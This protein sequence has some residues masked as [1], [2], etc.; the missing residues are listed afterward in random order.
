M[1]FEGISTNFN[2]LEACLRAYVD[3]QKEPIFLSSG[4]ED[5]FLGTYYFN[6]GLYHN[7]VAGL[8]HGDP[9]RPGSSF[10]FSAYRFHEDDPIP[11]RDGLRLG[12]RNGEEL[13]GH[14]FGDPKPTT[15]TSY[16]WTYE[17]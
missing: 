9:D 7:P 3:G 15:L 14:R 11:F 1:T 6:A 16:V 4:T 13:S 8:T 2:Y 10:R 17:W 12:W 5:Y